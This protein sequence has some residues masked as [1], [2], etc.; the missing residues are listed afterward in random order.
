[1]PESAAR[2]P[3]TLRVF[4]STGR[5]VR[6]LIDG[7]PLPADHAVVWDGSD[8]LGRPSAAGVYFYRLDVAGHHSL[9][10]KLVL[11]Q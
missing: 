9:T 2:R 8:A 7:A 1:M 3:A 6:T 5:L 10:R 4:D 11:M